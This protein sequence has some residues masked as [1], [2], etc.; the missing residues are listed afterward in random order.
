[1]RYSCWLSS[2]LL[3]A[4]LADT[5]RRS[6]TSLN[7]SS[8]LNITL[9]FP[10]IDCKAD[11]MPLHMDVLQ[12]HN[13]VEKACLEASKQHFHLPTGNISQN[14]WEQC[15]DVS[16]G[17]STG[18][19]CAMAFYENDTMRTKNCYANTVDFTGLNKTVGAWVCR[20]NLK[21][22][23]NACKFVPPVKPPELTES[24]SQRPYGVRWLEGRRLC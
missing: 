13:F 2:I 8:S 7:G 5:D 23:I 12:A 19:V 11:N 3:P 18:R 21:S 9:Y 10:K 4:C 22:I 17:N 6:S 16:D 24:R 14:Y 15:D 1:M 20:K